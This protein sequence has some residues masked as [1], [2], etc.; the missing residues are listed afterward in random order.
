MNNG[1]N[2]SN[3]AKSMILE[4]MNNTTESL[5]K[6]SQKKNEL[7]N[8]VTNIFKNDGSSN[9]STYYFINNIWDQLSNIIEKSND[10]VSNASITELGAIGHISMSL[11]ILLCLISIVV[12][13]S[14]NVIIQRFKLEEKYPKIAKYIR[15][16]Q[17]FQM[18]YFFI[19]ILTIVFILI[20]V[21][22]INICVL[23]KF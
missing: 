2:L 12:V 20:F 9:D 7:L 10:F 6:E 14:G 19:N 22:Y 11:A 21:I 15:I 4:N 17:Q 16:R 23:F 8:T 13:F 3:E 18:Y 5:M 1:E